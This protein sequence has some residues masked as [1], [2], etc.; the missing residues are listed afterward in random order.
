MK[1]VGDKVS[2]IRHPFAKN[3]YFSLGLG[4]VC[5]LLATGTMIGRGDGDLVRVYLFYGERKKLYFGKDWRGNRAGG[6]HILAD[7][8][9]GGAALRRGSPQRLGRACPEKYRSRPGA[10]P[11]QAA[12]MRLRHAPGLC[13]RRRV[14]Y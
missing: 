10:F 5:M 8:A 6:D 9:G 7:G 13:S 14:L 4:L 3:S 11:G 2:Y 12:E 1:Y